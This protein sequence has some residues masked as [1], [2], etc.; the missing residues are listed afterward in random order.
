[1]AKQWRSLLLCKPPQEMFEIGSN[2]PVSGTLGQFLAIERKHQE[3]SLQGCLKRL[4]YKLEHER[5]EGLRNNVTHARTEVKQLHH[6]L[7][8]YH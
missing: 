1:M 3:A 5:A 7:V 6:A 2:Q 4:R 8:R